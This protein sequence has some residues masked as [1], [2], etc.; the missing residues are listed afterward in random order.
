MKSLLMLLFFQDRKPLLVTVAVDGRSYRFKHSMEDL[1]N[2]SSSYPR[3]KCSI[4]DRKRRQS[5]AARLKPLFSKKARKDK[6]SV[7]QFV[8][9]RFRSEKGV[10]YLDQY[11]RFLFPLGYGTFL[12]IYFVIYMVNWLNNRFPRRLQR[13]LL[14]ESHHPYL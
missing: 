2:G 14:I 9:Q 11:S 4:H 5:L 10:H 3:R 8:K 1:E 7:L 6:G 12:T 13:E